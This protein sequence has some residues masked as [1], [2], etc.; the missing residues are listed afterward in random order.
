VPAKDEP[1]TFDEHIK[2]F[3]RSRDRQSMKFAFDLWSYNDV[4]AHAREIL[5]QVRNGSMPCDGAWAPEKV[6]AFTR[7]V[8]TG[9]QQ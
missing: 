7:W 1:V 5:E 6:E 9:M 2:S 4:K 8:D 3:F